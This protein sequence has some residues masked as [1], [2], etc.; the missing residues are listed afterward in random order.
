MDTTMRNVL[1]ALILT[2]LATFWVI[3]LMMRWRK[4]GQDEW[5]AIHDAG[6]PRGDPWR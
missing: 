4:Q 6:K 3:R 5:K 1:L 2:L